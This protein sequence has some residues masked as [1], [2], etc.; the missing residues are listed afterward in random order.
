MIDAS[1]HI[2]LVALPLGKGSDFFFVSVFLETDL[3]CH[4]DKV[5]E[6]ISGG[7]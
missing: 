1:K 7:F 5:V 3:L 6:G 2:T 4:L